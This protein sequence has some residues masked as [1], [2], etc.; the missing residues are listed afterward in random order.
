MSIEFL[1]FSIISSRSKDATG[2]ESIFFDFDRFNIHDIDVLVN[3]KPALIFK[4][5]FQ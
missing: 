2:E 5:D 4:F 3:Q 1:L